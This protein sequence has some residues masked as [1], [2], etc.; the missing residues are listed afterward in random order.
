MRTDVNEIMDRWTVRQRPDNHAST[1]AV[2]QADSVPEKE[3]GQ[4][5][6]GW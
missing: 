2:R 1:Q 6:L 5:L 3:W 4:A